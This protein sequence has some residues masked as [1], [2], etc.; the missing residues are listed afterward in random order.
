M[1]IG[2]EAYLH[3]EELVMCVCAHTCVC[4]CVCVFICGLVC[5]CMLYK[6][7]VCRAVCMYV[8]GHGCYDS[9]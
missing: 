5:V 7:M 9:S 2:V 8:E 1:V 3:V 6:A 4:V